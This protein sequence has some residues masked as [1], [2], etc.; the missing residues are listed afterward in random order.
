[1][2]ILKAEDFDRYRAVEPYAETMKNDDGE[3]EDWIA[4][5]MPPFIEFW[6]TEG[7]LVSFASFL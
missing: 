4:T 2:E 1:M 6:T 7:S 5:S 3:W